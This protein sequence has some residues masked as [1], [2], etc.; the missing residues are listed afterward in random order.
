M[1]SSRQAFENDFCPVQEDL[2]GAMY[3]ASE[4]G[5]PQLVESVSSDVRAMLAL[6]CYR[7]SHLHSLA[8]AIAASCDERELIQLGGRVGSTLYALSHETAVSRPASPSSYGNRKAITLSTKPLS[9]FTP[10]DDEL[11]DEAEVAVQDNRVTA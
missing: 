2:L 5:L 7:R 1:W 3:R 10:V 9:T 11:D 4:N 8:I 6:F